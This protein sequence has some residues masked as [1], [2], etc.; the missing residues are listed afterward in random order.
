MRL[1]RGTIALLLGSI[2]IIA[3][4]LVFTNSQVNAPT[5]EGTPV[6]TEETTGPLF[7]GLDAANL[8]ELEIAE[9][10]TGARTVLVR[11]TFDE[12]SSVEVAPVATEEPIS[13]ADA[14]ADTTGEVSIEPT[15]DATT[16]VEVTDEI[17][18][19]EEVDETAEAA[20]TDEATEEAELTDEAT[21]EATEAADATTE[22]TSEVVTGP[23]N[24]LDPLMTPSATFA[25]DA[26]VWVVSEATTLSDMGVDLTQAGNAAAVF[27]ALQSVTSFS[28]A[29]LA[30]FGLDAPR[31]TLTA[32]D[33][34]G[35]TYRIDIGVK[36]PTQ[37]RYYATI[38]GDNTVIYQIPSDLVESL[39]NLVA[40]PPYLP[41][42]T[43]TM[44]PTATAN[45][46]SEVQ[47]TETAAA[48]STELFGTLAV[49]TLAVPF[50]TLDVTPSQ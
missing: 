26:Q 36:N 1:N 38:N 20:A 29:S 4:V 30:S 25:P 42:L 22:V 16:E 47:Q 35:Q 34:S 48:I 37:P 11:T 9:P 8:T 17:A 24:T 6:A 33:A 43:P 28:D 45:P 18:L 13:T 39:T 31:Y 41:T 44:F 21:V 7:A 49:Q 27:G 50:I 3:A 32:T 2:V 46:F 15:A 40:N 12:A 5:T 23:T 14:T 19:T 10:S